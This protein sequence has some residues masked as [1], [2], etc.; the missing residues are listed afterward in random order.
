MS[1]KMR[2]NN[3]SASTRNN[4]ICKITLSKFE[5]REAH[6]NRDV[7]RRIDQHPVF[8][9]V[10]LPLPFDAGP[11]ILGGSPSSDPG[12]PAFQT[13]HARLEVS[14]ARAQGSRVTDFSAIC[15]EVW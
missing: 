1:G 13:S 4:P 9:F 2:Y 8:H 15:K 11:G 5:H 14:L 12:G 3:L 6:D 10:P 7:I